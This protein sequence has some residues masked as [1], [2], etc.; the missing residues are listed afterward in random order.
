MGWTPIPGTDKVLTLGAVDPRS[1]VL[2]PLSWDLRGRQ[3]V[4]LL[5]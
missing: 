3:P 1:S 5:T 4:V 2:I